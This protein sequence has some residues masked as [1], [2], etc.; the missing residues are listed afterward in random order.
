MLTEVTCFFPPPML[1]KPVLQLL[2]EYSKQQTV[3]SEEANCFVQLKTESN[4]S[5]RECS[6]RDIPEGAWL[7]AAFLCMLHPPTEV[8]TSL[9]AIPPHDL[10]T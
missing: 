3:L 2:L 7:H 5:L 4:E 1:W 9:A 10:V 8:T 6:R